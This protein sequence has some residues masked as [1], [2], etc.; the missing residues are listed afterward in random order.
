[1]S[2]L[3]MVRVDLRRPAPEPLTPRQAIKLEIEQA[4]AAHRLTRH[5]WAK[6]RDTTDAELAGR[7]N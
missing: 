1:M 5:L 4:R 3:D 6:L 7:A 2:L